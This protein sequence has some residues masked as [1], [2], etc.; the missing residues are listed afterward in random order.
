MASNLKL[1]EIQEFDLQ[2]Q[3]S[4]GWGTFISASYLG[5]L[6]R[7]LPNFLDVNLDP[8]TTTSKTIT[9][10]G[11]DNSQGPLGPTGA[12]VTIPVVYT[13]Y[14]NTSLLGANATKFSNI[15]E[16]ISNVNS[17]YNALV[18]EILNRSLKSVT[19]DANYTWSHSL[20]FEQNANTLGA[21][22]SW[23]DPYGN[24]RVNYGN[25][26]WNIPNRFVAYAIYNFPNLN[27]GNP[28]K[29]LVNDWSLDDSFQMQNGLPYTISVS[30]YTSAS[31]GSYW[32]GASG[33]T[34]IPSIG[35]NTMR[36]P[37]RMVDDVRFQKEI[38]FGKGRNLQLMCNMFNIANHQNVTSINNTAYV[39]SGSTATFQSAT[40]GAVTNTNSQGFLYTPAKL[41]SPPASISKAA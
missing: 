5:A 10:A 27:G 8:T 20:D 30:S 4:V 34:M 17:N 39:L 25:S 12:T 24:A 35:V 40:Y 19:F 21:G 18:G 22:Q 16:M 7:R 6:G 1:P 26:Q 3:H 32:N 37:R 33:S 15:T 36:Y 28:L 2:V 41:N 29:W 38:A 31:I 9:I 14:G 11:D 23:Y 13:A